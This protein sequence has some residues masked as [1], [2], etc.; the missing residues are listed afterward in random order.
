MYY[1]LSSVLM[2]II[3]LEE[4]PDLDEARRLYGGLHSFRYDNE[5]TLWNV[6]TLLTV[7]VLYI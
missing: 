2:C 3:V 5:L 1:L 7:H 6:F 4:G